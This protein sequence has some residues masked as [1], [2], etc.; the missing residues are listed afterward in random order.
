MLAAGGIPGSVMYICTSSCSN[1][2]T[3][4]SRGTSHAPTAPPRLARMLVLG[5]IKRN[6]DHFRIHLSKMRA[7]TVTQQISRYWLPVKLTLDKRTL[8]YGLSSARAKRT[9]AAVDKT[10]RKRQQQSRAQ[11][12]SQ[13]IESI[14]KQRGQQVTQSKRA[15]ANLPMHHH[16]SSQLS[17]PS[18]P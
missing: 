6:M 14:A 7:W 17:F 3:T 11:L 12:R 5:H 8:P 9:R 10:M 1:K 4:T 16:P 2:T 13:R 15:N 18:R